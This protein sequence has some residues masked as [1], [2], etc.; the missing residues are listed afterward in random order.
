MSTTPKS[1]YRVQL[2]AEFTLDDAA[3][4]VDYLVELGI[5]AIYLSPILTATP[6][7]SHGY[8]CTDPTTIDPARGGEAG[9]QRL[10]A[11]CR[12]AGLGVVVDIVPNHLGIEVPAANPAWWDVLRD[13]RESP[14][15]PWFDIDWM[16]RAKS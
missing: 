11:A 5:D 7:S 10:L 12:S 4:L 14:T 1:T 6:G 15:A 13:G 16:S 8:D 9:W 3:D 2:S